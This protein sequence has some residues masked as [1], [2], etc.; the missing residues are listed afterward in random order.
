MKNTII[1]NL[2]YFDCECL[3]AVNDGTN[4]ITIEAR[5]SDFAAPYILLTLMDGTAVATDTLQLNGGIISYTID[6]ELYAVDGSITLQVIDGAYKSPEIT[7]IGAEN[8][9]GANL[10]LNEDSDVQ[11]T[12]QVASVAPSGDG[13]TEEWQAAINAN[14]AARHSHSN[15]G[16][17]DA[18][19]TALTNMEIEA[20][21][22]N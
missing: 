5:K 20:L 22:S 2:N 1:Y 11:F 18:I 6:P 12:C 16:A 10:T 21:L 7:I 17:L 13:F 8:E 9:N 3:S 19:E 15:K 4:S 14:T